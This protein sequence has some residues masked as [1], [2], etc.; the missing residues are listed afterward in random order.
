[1]SMQMS[2]IIEVDLGRDGW[3]PISTKDTTMCSALQQ[4]DVY[5][6]RLPNFS[7]AGFFMD[8]ERRLD[9]AKMVQVNDES[10]RERAIR[11]RTLAPAHASSSSSFFNLSPQV[12]LRAPRENHQPLHSCVPLPSC[13]A[14]N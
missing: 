14:P 5:N 13:S 12:Q 3:Q 1:M 10:L 7:E 11:V 6:P 9:F 4:Y 8:T 2:R